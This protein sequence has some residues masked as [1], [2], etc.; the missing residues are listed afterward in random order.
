MRATHEHEWEAVPGLPSAL[1]MGLV[2]MEPDLGTALT[3]V[4]VGLGMVYLAGARPGPGCPARGRGRPSRGL[5]AGTPSSI[6]FAT[7]RVPGR[8]RSVST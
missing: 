6:A 1:P 3:L 8:S 5:F 7:S 4:P 2:M